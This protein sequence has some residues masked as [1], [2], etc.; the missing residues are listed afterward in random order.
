MAESFD[1][2]ARR[3]S[4][5][6]LEELRKNIQALEDSINR[7]LRDDDKLNHKD[8]EVL[9]VAAD[10]LQQEDAALSQPSAASLSRSAR[11]LGETRQQLDSLD[12]AGVQKYQQE[13]DEL[14]DRIEKNIRNIIMQMQAS[15][16]GE[17]G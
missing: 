11:R 10:N 14:A 13:W 5:E 1:R 7:A 3:I 6:Y 17:T 8:R 4:G 12:S 15:V 2:Q 9:R 16:R